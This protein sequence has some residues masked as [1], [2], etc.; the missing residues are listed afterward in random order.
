MNRTNFQQV[1]RRSVAVIPQDPL[2]FTG[3][4][5]QNLTPSDDALI[6]DVSGSKPSVSDEEIHRLL[7]ECRLK[8]LVDSLG[9]LNAQMQPA[10]FSLGQKQLFAAARAILR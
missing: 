9:G 3:T 10:A 8:E 7:L 1:L 4:I 6:D 2:L 5:R